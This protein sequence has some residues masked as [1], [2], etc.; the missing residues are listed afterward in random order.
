[1]VRI[2][3]IERE[4]FRGIVSEVEDVLK[5]RQERLDKMKEAERVKVANTINLEGQ[6]LRQLAIKLEVTA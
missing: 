1:M 6:I 3:D 5:R 2:P 4:S